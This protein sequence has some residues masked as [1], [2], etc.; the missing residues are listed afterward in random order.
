MKVNA[1]WGFGFVDLSVVVCS[2][3]V[4]CFFSE[5]STAL[6]VLLLFLHLLRTKSLSSNGGYRFGNS[7]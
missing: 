6:E 7:I 5:S 3:G 1:V 2:L 4:F